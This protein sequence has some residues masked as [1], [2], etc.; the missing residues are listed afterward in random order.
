MKELDPVSIRK[1]TKI[2][3]GMCVIIETENA[4]QKCYVDFDLDALWSFWKTNMAK[5]IQIWTRIHHIVDKHKRKFSKKLEG[6]GVREVLFGSKP[7]DLYETL[8]LNDWRFKRQSFVW[9]NNGDESDDEADW[10][11]KESDRSYISK[12]SRLILL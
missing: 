7:C 10:D 12:F 6:D 5:D 11:S 2:D 8:F 9:I 1:N 3:K 4:C